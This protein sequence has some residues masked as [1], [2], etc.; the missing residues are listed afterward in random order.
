V[1]IARLASSGNETRP[2]RR[3]GV[4]IVCM[5]ARTRT[6]PGAK[7]ESGRADAARISRRDSRT[8]ARDPLAA[9][10]RTL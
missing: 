9:I 3:G 7:S 8:W 10:T 6:S 5:A 2:P 4:A 1:P